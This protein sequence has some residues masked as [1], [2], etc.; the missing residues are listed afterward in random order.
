[1]RKSTHVLRFNR[2]LN[3]LQRNL[4]LPVLKLFQISRPGSFIWHIQHLC[5][6]VACRRLNR[7]IFSFFF[8][9]FWPIFHLC[10]NWNC[11]TKF[12]NKSH[13]ISGTTFS[14]NTRRLRQRCCFRQEK[15]IPAGIWFRPDASFRIWSTRQIKLNLI[16]LKAIGTICHQRWTGFP[17]EF[18][19]NWTQNDRK[20]WEICGGYKNNTRTELRTDDWSTIKLRWK[21]FFFFCAFV[22]RWK[23]VIDSAFPSFETFSERKNKG[24]RHDS[25]FRN[26]HA[27][28]TAT[29]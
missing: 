28:I 8:F 27:S 29:G 5:V 24:T 21:L 26:R 12:S 23:F 9:C 18:R 3:E 4:L 1:M 19:K 11:F 22:F 13:D 10:S 16:L 6:F 15:K 14:Y 20:R 25:A 7:Q 17:E 2:F